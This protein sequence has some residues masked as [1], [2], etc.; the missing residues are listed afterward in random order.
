MAIEYQKNTARFDG[1]VGADE[2]E[3]LLEWLQ[4]HTKGKLAL[5]A[6]SHLHAANLQVLMAAKAQISAWPEDEVLAAWLK[7]ALAQQE[8]NQ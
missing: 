1:V 7:S 3:T 4:K 5:S 6:C 2:A 8:L